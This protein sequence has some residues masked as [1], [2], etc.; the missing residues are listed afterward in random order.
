MRAVKDRKPVAHALR[1]PYTEVSEQAAQEQLQAIAD[2]PWGIKFPMI[3][4]S[5]ARVW[6]QVTPFFAFPPDA[7]PLPN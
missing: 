2:G 4:Q 7:R 5:W 1:P 6:E 3:G